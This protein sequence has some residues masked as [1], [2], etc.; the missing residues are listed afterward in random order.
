MDFVD[1]INKLTGTT[2]TGSTQGS[3]SSS[4]SACSSYDEVSIFTDNLDAMPTSSTEMKEDEYF[5]LEKRLEEKKYAEEQGI[6]KNFDETKLDPKE[7]ESLEVKPN[8]K[9]LSNE[10]KNYTFKTSSGT[11][12]DLED[13]EGVKIYE[14]KST[15]DPTLS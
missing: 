5:L 4:S 8:N 2:S 11:K 12:I 14:N 15:G 7:W 3:D 1:I 6:E 10:V 13:I 9:F